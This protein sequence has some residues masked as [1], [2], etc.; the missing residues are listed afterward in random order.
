MKITK[1]PSNQTYQIQFPDKLYN[2]KILINSLFNSQLLQ[3]HNSIITDD[4]QTII[5]K[6]NQLTNFEDFLLEQYK[7]YT[8]DQFNSQKYEIAL[9]IIID[10]L[11]QLQSLYRFQHTFYTFSLQ[12]LFVK[13]N[14][15]F[16]YLSTDHL[17]P[18]ETKGES[19][20]FQIT[21]KIP[22]PKDELGLFLS[23]EIQEIDQL[24]FSVPYQTIYYSLGSLLLSFISNKE[25]PNNIQEE[26]IKQLLGPIKET[27]LYWFILRIMNRSPER[28][29][30]I[31]FF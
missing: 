23:P 4:F 15:Q 21:F 17:L 25:V 16:F 10:L 26:E 18:L 3:S 12:N 22:F 7:T 20:N 13:D 5:I 9:H 29:Y 24:P 27:R 8:P 6:A 30:V 11:K 31:H 2:T 28:R 14:Q 19:N 1:N